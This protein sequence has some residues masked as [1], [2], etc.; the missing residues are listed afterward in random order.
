VESSSCPKIGP[1]PVEAPR[2]LERAQACEEA[3][4]ASRLR[5]RGPST[6]GTPYRAFLLPASLDIG[7]QGE[8]GWGG[9]PKEPADWRRQACIPGEGSKTVFRPTPFVALPAPARSRRYAVSRG[10]CLG[11]GPWDTPHAGR[12]PAFVGLNLK[13]HPSASFNQSLRI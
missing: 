4:P 6:G 10:D 3:P 7:P 1:E 9:E 11:K 2:M 5:P 8:E 13:K 12:L